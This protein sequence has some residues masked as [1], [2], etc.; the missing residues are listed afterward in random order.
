MKRR[1][2]NKWPRQKTK[3][4]L[5]DLEHAK[6]AVILSLRSFES[7]RS[8]RHSIDEFVAWYC[9]APRL[10]FNKAVV[11]RYRL[12]LED[13]HLAAGTINVRLAAVRRLAYEAADSGLLSPDLAAGIRRV[14]GAKR[15]GARMGNW[16]TAQQARMLWQLPDIS[17]LKGKRDRAILAVLLGCGLRRRELTELTVEHLQLREDHWAILDL[18][19]KAGHVRTVPVPFW[20]KRTVD[21]W[22]TASGIS[23]GRLF[24]RV[25]RTG[26]IWG[27]EMTE[28]VV[29]H[30]VKQYAEEVGILKLAP[31]DLC[32]SCA[33]LCHS[34][35]GEI[36]QIQFLL[37]HVSVQ[38][39]EKYLGCKQHLREAVND[40]IGIEPSP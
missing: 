25:C 28:K 32:R 34:A 10:S 20:V 16:L 7:Q 22:L 12:H 17:T 37:G 39:T 14:K 15:L 29:W 2:R 1:F 30:V 35:G 21:E 5:P 31:H 8:Y 6:I 36:E 3:L 33:R 26:M 9:S 11:L 27:T 19:G 13:R 18:V 38:T 4:G 24:R 23:H 40:Q